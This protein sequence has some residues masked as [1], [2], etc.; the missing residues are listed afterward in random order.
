MRRS[1]G[2]TGRAMS[3]RS[4]SAISARPTTRCAKPSASSRCR[5]EPRAIGPQDLEDQLMSQRLLDFP[6]VIIDS[7]YESPRINGVLIRALADEI[8]ASGLRVM[9]G[10]NIADAH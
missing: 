2:S 5:S 9:T 3:T 4:T 1:A 10:L 7:D 6:V 8:R